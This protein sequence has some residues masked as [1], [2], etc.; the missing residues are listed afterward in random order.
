MKSHLWRRFGD[1]CLAYAMNVKSPPRRGFRGWVSRRGTPPG[2]GLVKSPLW[3]GFGDRCLAYIM[4]VK[5]PSSEGIQG[6][7]YW[8]GSVFW[9]CDLLTGM[10]S[11]LPPF[12]ASRSTALSIPDCF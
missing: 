6:W 12:T 5:V 4:N 9:C 11:S 8:R 7:V 3:R 1:R 10:L 2:R